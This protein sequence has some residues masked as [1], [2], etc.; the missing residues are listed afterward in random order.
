MKTAVYLSI[1]ADT[2]ARFAHIRTQ[3][4]Q[5]NKESQANALGNVLSEMACEVIEQVFMVL[6]QENQ[7]HS[8][9]GESEKVIQQI[10]EAIRKYMPWSVSF[11][12][13]DRLI[14]LVEYLS[15]T[16]QIEDDHIYMTYP[17]ESQLA[18]QVT[19]SA[20]K[21]AAGNQ[22]EIQHALKLLTEVI[23]VGVTHLIREPKKC[24]K[25]NFVVDKTLNGVINM[26]TH[27]GYKRLEKLGTQL[28]QQMASTY[29]DYFLKFMRQQA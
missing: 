27:L 23:D 3:L 17:V 26:T 19:A 5:G 16:L 20:Q 10:L 6:L 9:T 12:G 25:F 22:Q 24:L 21:L 28:D 1:H 18:Q 29:V 15:K 14:P 11:F 4:L 2:Y 7:Q 13:N 8:K